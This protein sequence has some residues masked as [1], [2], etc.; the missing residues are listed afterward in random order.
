MR[1]IGDGLKHLVSLEELYLSENKI[2]KIEGVETLKNLLT[3]DLGY[4]KVEKLEG[5]SMLP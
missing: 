3:L 2:A 1:N 5:I 4:N